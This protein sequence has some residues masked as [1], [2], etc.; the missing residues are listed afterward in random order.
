[1][2][3]KVGK[4]IA[5]CESWFVGGAGMFASLRWGMLFV[6]VVEDRILLVEVCEFGLR[7]VCSCMVGSI[8]KDI[9]GTW[10]G[11]LGAGCSFGKKVGLR[12]MIVWVGSSGKYG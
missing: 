3:L 5:C 9:C 11:I 6:G 4:F 7:G 10:V 12:M 2:V 8:A 1:M